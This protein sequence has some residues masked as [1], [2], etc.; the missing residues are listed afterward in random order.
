MS[1]RKAT[2]KSGSDWTDDELTFFRIVIKPTKDPLLVLESSAACTSLVTG[3]QSVDHNVVLGSQLDKFPTE[4]GPR[5]IVTAL[6]CARVKQPNNESAVDDFVAL[7]FRQLDTDGRFLVRSVLSSSLLVAFLSSS[8]PLR[9]FRLVCIF[10]TTCRTRME[11][12]L[13][14]SNEGKDAKSDV[15]VLEVD[16]AGF[17]IRVIVVEVLIFLYYLCAHN[18]AR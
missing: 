9:F 2:P 15:A 6:W 5:S 17:L 18:T 8:L 14:M 12:P 13:K 4:A 3:L 16:A 10:W 11:T 7:L 1:K